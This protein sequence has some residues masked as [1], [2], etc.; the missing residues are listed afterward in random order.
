M[1]GTQTGL[2]QRENFAF[3]VVGYIIQLVVLTERTW[4]LRHFLL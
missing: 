3:D 1:R 4:R 2:K